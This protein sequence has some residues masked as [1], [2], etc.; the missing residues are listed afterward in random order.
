[1]RSNIAVTR[2]S[3]SI[4]NITIIIIVAIILYTDEKN[5][6]FRLRIVHAEGPLYLLAHSTQQA[7]KN[8]DVVRF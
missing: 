5:L 1:L 6:Q 3:H 4:I 2:S 7:Y 8:S